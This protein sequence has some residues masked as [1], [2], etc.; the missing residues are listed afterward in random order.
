[1]ERDKRSFGKVNG[2]RARN[3]GVLFVGVSLFV[4]QLIVPSLMLTLGGEA[5]RRVSK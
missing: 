1:M 5:L 4:P 3:A 2:E